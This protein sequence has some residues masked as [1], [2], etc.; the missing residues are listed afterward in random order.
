MLKRQ[1]EINAASPEE[2]DH[3]SFRD[4]L[5]TAAKKGLISQVEP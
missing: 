3:S 2:I 5:R 1:L 4:I